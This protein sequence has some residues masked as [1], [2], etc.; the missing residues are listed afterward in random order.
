MAP[1]GRD[2]DF[3]GQ[4]GNPRDAAEKEI[5]NLLCGCWPPCQ[6]PLHP[7]WLTRA[8]TIPVTEKVFPLFK[9]YVHKCNLLNE[10]PTSRSWKPY[11]GQGQINKRILE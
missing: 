6:F 9:K 5:F 11:F 7:Q 2:D 10:V 1:T 8:I 4:I 3:Q